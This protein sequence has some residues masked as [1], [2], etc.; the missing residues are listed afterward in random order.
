MTTRGGHFP[1]ERCTGRKEEHNPIS[2]KIIHPNHLK[3]APSSKYMLVSSNSHGHERK[4]VNTIQDT[5]TTNIEA[6]F[7]ESGPQHLKLFHLVKIACIIALQDKVQQHTRIS[8]NSLAPP[9]WYKQRPPNLF[10]P[11]LRLCPIR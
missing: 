3:A 4:P 8:S 1:Q 10:N 2:R 5:T 7:K 9:Q 11:M 6:I